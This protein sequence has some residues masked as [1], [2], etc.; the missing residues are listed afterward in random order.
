LLETKGFDHNFLRPLGLADTE[1][2]LPNHDPSGAPLPENRA[3]N[4]R[5]VIRVQKNLPARSSKGAGSRRGARP[6]AATASGGGHS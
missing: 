2:L 4:R 1:P 3:Q 6:G 5:I